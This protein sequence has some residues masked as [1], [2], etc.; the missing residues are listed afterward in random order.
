MTALS[1][2]NKAKQL[3][4]KQIRLKQI[5]KSLN[6]NKYLK[7]AFV[8]LFLVIFLIENE[9]SI[10]LFLTT[11]PFDIPKVN[12]YL[13]CYPSGSVEKFLT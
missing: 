12:I 3:R 2:N 4:L 9:N 1:K 8:L 10:L 6:N 7:Y 13:F 5:I 11:K